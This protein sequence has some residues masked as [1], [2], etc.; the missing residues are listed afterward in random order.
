[1]HLQGVSA[2]Y[3]DRGGVTPIHAAIEG[4][5][6]DILELLLLVCSTDFFLLPILNPGSEQR[7]CRC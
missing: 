3:A 7:E 6:V 1:M 2:N 5:N 4:N